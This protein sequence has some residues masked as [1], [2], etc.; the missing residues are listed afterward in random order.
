MFLLELSILGLF[1]FLE[2]RNPHDSHL[3]FSTHRHFAFCLPPFRT[4]WALIYLRNLC[5]NNE[6]IRNFWNTSK[7]HFG[8]SR[9]NIAFSVLWPEHS[10][11]LT[12]S[13]CNIFPSRHCLEK[14]NLRWERDRICILILK[15]NT[16]FYLQKRFSVFFMFS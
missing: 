4:R 16:N 7:T 15:Y 2:T 9:Q 10:S 5:E 8:S 12:L 6:L 3:P 14:I 1:Y 13:F 11:R